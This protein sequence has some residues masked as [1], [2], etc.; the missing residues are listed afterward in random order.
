MKYRELRDRARQLDQEAA[1]KR[2][3]KYF[4]NT[5][6]WF[7]YLGLLRQNVVEPKRT[8]VTLAEALLAADL[9][10]RIY[11]LLP[12]LLINIPE[13][14]HFE[15]GDVPQEL[16]DIVDT[17]KHRRPLKPYRGIPAEKY[18][19]WLSAEPMNIAKRRLSFRAIPRQRQTPTTEIGRF[20]RDSRVKL[21]LTQE[22]LAQR[23]DVSVRVIR[24]LEQG[25]M[26][27][28]LAN[29]SKVL[30]VFSAQLSIS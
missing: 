30:A 25:R 9:E 27:A 20:V 19:H 1:L 10:P 11:E 17:I 5:L 28:S 2:K 29:V 8:I 7:A 26:S 3:E 22:A 18:M 12:A 24:D 15:K 16:Q 13:A 14:L 21:A 4:R 23:V 6:A